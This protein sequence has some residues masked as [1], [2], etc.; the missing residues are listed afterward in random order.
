FREGRW[1]RTRTQHVV[2]LR[3]LP[4][5]SAP[6][7]VVGAILQH[8]SYNGVNERRSGAGK[9]RWPR[10][11]RA[12]PEPSSTVIGGSSPLE[13]TVHPPISHAAARFKVVTIDRRACE[14]KGY[15]PCELCGLSQSGGVTASPTAR[16]WRR[17]RRVSRSAPRC[18]TEGR[19]RRCRPRG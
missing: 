14:A 18:P 16:R 15:N 17:R 2:V 10:R 4:P 8:R 13:C 1:T 12:G 7:L 3:L 6:Q 19:Q 5:T 9:L 11:G